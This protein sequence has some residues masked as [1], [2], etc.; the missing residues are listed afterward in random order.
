MDGQVLRSE[1]GTT[2]GD[3]LAMPMYMYALAT[4]P[5]INRLGSNEDVTQVW[6]T[7][8]ASA[9]GGLGSLR[10]WWDHLLVKFPWTSLWIPRKC[11]QNMA[12]GQGAVPIQGK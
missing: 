9:A 11:L 8:D 7:D 3:P 1:E 2:Q 5:L 12:G 10:E 4:V 6:Y